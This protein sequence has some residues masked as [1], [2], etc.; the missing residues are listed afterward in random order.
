M[1]I[2]KRKN[3]RIMWLRVLLWLA[4][5]AWVVTAFLTEDGFISGVVLFVT[6]ILMYLDVRKEIKKR[7]K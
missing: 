2:C 7:F 6:V 3:K 5:A 1:Y 4:A